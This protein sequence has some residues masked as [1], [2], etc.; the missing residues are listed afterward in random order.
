MAI[1]MKLENQFV[2]KSVAEI[3]SFSRLSVSQLV[4]C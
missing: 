1:V 3:V 2:E 4:C